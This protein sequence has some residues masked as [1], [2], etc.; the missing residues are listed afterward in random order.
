M[1]K[2]YYHSPLGYINITIDSQVVNALS[3]GSKSCAGSDLMS[4]TDPTAREL[5]HQLTRYFSDSYMKFTVPVQAK[6]T[7]FQQSVWKEMCMI[8]AGSTISYGKL[9]A[10]LNT[11]AR[12][13][14]NA[15]RM[16]P[17]PLLIPC[18]RVV[19]KSG[20]GGYSGETSGEMMTIKKW[21]LNHEGVVV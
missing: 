12:A 5:C 16:N 6:G 3:L 4:A 15:C 14:G 11:S 17:I 8:P 18:H 2:F 9:A 21:L 10:K 7:A 19:A 13:V 1:N 20:L